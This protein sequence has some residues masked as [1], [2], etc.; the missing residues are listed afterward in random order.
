MDVKK[1]ESWQM[2]WWKI[3]KVRYSVKG[4]NLTIFTL[5]VRYPKKGEGKT[6]QVPELV[7]WTFYLSNLKSVAVNGPDLRT[8]NP[9][10][11]WKKGYI[12]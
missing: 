7:G 6:W 3:G 10:Y 11:S 4:N 2:D 8:K 9:K 12:E 5:E 1:D